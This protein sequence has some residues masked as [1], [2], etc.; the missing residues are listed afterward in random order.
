[1]NEYSEKTDPTLVDLTL[2]GN[3][4]AF[5]ELVNRHQ[6]KALGTAF[7]V[8]SN[9]WSAEDAAQDAFVSAWTHLSALEDK[10]RFGAWVCAITKN[11]ACRIVRHYAAAVEV[12]LDLPDF[13]EPADTKSSDASELRE[14]IDSLSEVLR[15]TVKLHYFGG[16][17][18]EE[19]A[20]MLDVPVGTVKW[21]LSEARKQLRKGY[22]IMEKTYDENEDFTARVMRQVEELKFWIT[23]LNKT[24]FE[25]AY[26]NVLAA[27]ESL[28][29]SDKKQY[30]LADVLL[31]GYWWLDRDK[32][33]I[34]EKMKVAAEKSH[35]E[36]VMEAI[37]SDE[38]FIVKDEK[39]R[40][41]KIVSTI[42]PRLEAE[43][44]VKPLGYAW[45]WLGYTYSELGEREKMYDAFNKVLE[46][47]DK[48][49]IYYAIAL[50]AIHTEEMIDRFGYEDTGHDNS[51]GYTVGGVQLKFISGKTILWL[52]PGFNRWKW[53]PPYVFWMGSGVDRLV[54][55]PGMKVGDTITASDGESKLTY[56]SDN[57]TVET[58][59]G[60][61]ENCSLFSFRGLNNGVTVCDTWFCPGVGIVA[62][63]W[64]RGSNS[65]RVDLA[66]YSV[67]GDG[68]LPLEVGNKWNYK[69]VSDDR[70]YDDETI[71]EVIYN[72][73]N[74]VNLSESCYLR[75]IGYQDTWSGIKRCVRETYYS[76]NKTPKLNRSVLK[77]LDRAEVLAETKLQKVQAR[78]AKR[79][80]TRIMDTDRD[81]NPDCTEIGRWNFFNTERIERKGTDI[82]Y[83]YLTNRYAFEWKN[84]SYWCDEAS[85]ILYN[86]LYNIVS[87]DL[88]DLI[89]SDKWVPGY[90]QEIDLT[91]ENGYIDFPDGGKLTLDVSGDET[92]ETPAGVFENCRHVKYNMHSEKGGDWYFK[93]DFELWYAKG[94]GLVK[95]SR[96]LKTSNIWQLTEYRGTGEGYFPFGDGFFRRYEPETLGEG[97]HASVE[98]EFVTDGEQ[99]YIIKDALGTQ[100]REVFEEL[101]RRAKEQ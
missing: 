30:A 17:K 38:I 101:E 45:F 43:K 86:F 42:I 40:A 69:L 4:A 50:A 52:L 95:L 82:L 84:T 12:S 48:S 67:K 76:E 24:G 66:K 59:A 25:E 35:N 97:L 26:K 37:V 18:V 94:V 72:D 53:T 6:K 88:G 46:V 65:H 31:Q 91:P 13:P 51:T 33:E 89:W 80:M 75:T 10:S 71:Y 74:T 20:K 57:E 58:P 21:R 34:R 16:Y 2:L 5:E 1:M 62:Q 100:D 83:D 54:L 90:H 63:S 27:V 73:G 60:T 36:D 61:F 77:Y 70:I 68:L 93:G 78:I 8:T 64:T 96:P 29:E 23:K 81:V 56:I 22:G 47:I 14:T 28:D 87:F 39:E 7:K 49:S 11:H 44:W 32:E 15:E 3:S 41:E 99:M 92:T 9:I 19:I 79:V 55:D 98:Y 85:K